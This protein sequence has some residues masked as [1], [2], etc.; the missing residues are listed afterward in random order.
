MDFMAGGGAS[1][2]GPPDATKIIIMTLM[3]R[4][5]I[6]EISTVKRIAAKRCKACVSYLDSAAAKEDP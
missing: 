3:G 1:G 2:V 6:K 5:L 4:A